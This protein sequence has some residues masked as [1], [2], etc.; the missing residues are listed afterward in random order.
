MH[1]QKQF[2]HQILSFT[3][4]GRI[5]DAITLFKLNV[6]DYPKSANVYDSLGEAYEKKGDKENA[7]A[8]YRKA[9]SIDPRL[10]TA[11][12]AVKRLSER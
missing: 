3:N 6:E 10:P 9:L 1:R 11:L 12:A 2:F 7:L 5:D 4:A 8:S